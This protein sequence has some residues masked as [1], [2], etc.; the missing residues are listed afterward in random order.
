VHTAV[1]T[2]EGELWVCGQGR[3][4]QLGLGDQDNR[5]A[6]M[7][8]GAETAFGGLQVLTA[9]CGLNYT[10]AVTK[11]GALWTFG[12]G[13][14][15]ALGHND[16]NNRLVPTCI[17]AKHYGNAIIV[18]VA[19]GF[20]HSTAVTE[21][22]ALYT[23]G[24]A[25]GLRHTDG[26]AKLVPTHVTTNSLHLLRVGRC[27]DLPPMHALAFAMGT[28]M[29]LGSAAPTALPAGSGSQRRSQRQQGKTP[30][31]ADKGKDCEYVTMPCE[32]VQR[33]VEACVS[34]PEGR[35]GELEGVVRL[36]GGGM[37]KMRGST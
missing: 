34:W 10:L 26:Q 9:G 5:L 16:R 13:T 29:R 1:V 12:W 2:I 6:P 24:H 32:L 14:H 36:L 35:A 37:T 27:H 33:V 19:A 22:G 20:M 30:A 18:S 4:G 3:F 15:G 21:K 8:V 17:E 28:H 11:D 7:L 31:A 25:S 23:W